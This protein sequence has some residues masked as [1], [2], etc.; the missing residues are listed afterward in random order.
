[1]L[2]QVVWDEAPRDGAGIEDGDYVE[3]HTGWDIADE[4]VELKVQH[5]EK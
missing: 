3:G 4:A 1:M 5:C 2:R